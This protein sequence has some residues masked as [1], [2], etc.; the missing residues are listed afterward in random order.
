MKRSPSLVAGVV[1]I[2][3][4]SGMAFL[5][6]IWT[7]YDPTTVNSTNV[8]DPFSWQHLLGTDQLGR[9]VLSI[10][11]A[12]SRTSL[13][14]AAAAVIIAMALGLSVGI[15]AATVSRRADDFITAT[16]AI[17]LAF[18]A[19]L[20][21]LIL[22]AT[23]GPSTEIAIVAIGLATSTSVA[24]VT[25]SEARRILGTSYVIAAR[26]AGANTTEVIRRHVL[27]NLLPS[28]TVQASGVASIAIAAEATLSY[29]GL[30][31]TPPHPSWG[32]MLASTQQYI[33]VTPL[34]PLWPA[35]VIALAIYGCNLLGDGLRE[36]FDPTLT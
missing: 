24:L 2:G 23:Y 3:A 35:L 15:L 11:M 29:L 9:D 6:N 10:L 22:A 19:L 26:Y 21:A 18:P 7:P 1:I 16:L 34:L 5:G 30:G 14:A 28:I 17:G 13:A 27:R 12:G 36:Y 8:F 4:L 33:L 25:R 32:R 31:T 20:V